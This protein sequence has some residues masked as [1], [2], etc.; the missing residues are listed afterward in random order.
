MEPIEEAEFFLSFWI[1]VMIDTQ[2]E[3][4]AIL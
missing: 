1:H 2:L 4:A 3:D